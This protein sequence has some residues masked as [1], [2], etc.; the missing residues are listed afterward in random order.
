M[1]FM[2]PDFQGKP[3]CFKKGERELLRKLLACV[4]AGTVLLSAFTVTSYFAAGSVSIVNPP[5]H[6]S[7]S[8]QL[9]MVENEVVD[10]PDSFLSSSSMGSSIPTRRDTIIFSKSSGS[11]RP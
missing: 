1:F 7:S 3:G 10:I 5:D 11:P 2:H 4:M 9:G 8:G 6:Q